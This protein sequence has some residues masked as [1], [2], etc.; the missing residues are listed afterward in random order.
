MAFSEQAIKLHAVFGEAVVPNLVLARLAT[1]CLWYS[2]N[3]W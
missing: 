2:L 1:P 3:R